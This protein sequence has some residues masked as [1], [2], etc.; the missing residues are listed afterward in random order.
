MLYEYRFSVSASTFNQVRGD[1]FDAVDKN[2]GGERIGKKAE[3]RANAEAGWRGA[4]CS[5][6]FE[7]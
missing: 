5:K 3:G 4:G 1:G 6:V 7:F 2:T